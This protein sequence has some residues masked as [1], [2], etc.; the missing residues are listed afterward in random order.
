MNETRVCYCD[1]CDKIF[2]IKS[3]SKQINSKTHKNKE[4][5]GTVVEENNFVNPAIDEVKYLLND[6]TKDCRKIIFSFI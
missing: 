2:N 1:V 6:T 3:K 5:N 4:K